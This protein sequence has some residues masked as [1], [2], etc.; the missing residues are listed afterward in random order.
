M[1]ILK[2]IELSRPQTLEQVNLLLLAVHL[3][4]EAEPLHMIALQFVISLN[5]SKYKRRC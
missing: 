3:K 2:A 5:A 1:N 4:K